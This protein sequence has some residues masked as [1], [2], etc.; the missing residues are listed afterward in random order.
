MNE[1]QRPSQITWRRFR[2]NR[3][4]LTGAI[5]L[6]ILYVLA[7]FAGFFS[8]YSPTNDEFRSH[9]YHP[10]TKIRFRDEGGNFHLRPFVYR[11]YLADIRRLIYTESKPL[12]IAHKNPAANT[13][14]YLPDSWESEDP[15]LILENES[16]K[17]LARVH[18]ME[19]TSENSGW[20]VA[21]VPLRRMPATSHLVIKSTLGDSVTFPVQNQRASFSTKPV[22]PTFDLMDEAG[23]HLLAYDTSLERIP[24]L[25]FV[26]GSDYRIFGVIPCNRHLFGVRSPGHIFLFGSDQWGRDIFSRV[27]YGAQISLSIGL[28]GVLVTTLF[29]LFLG[30]IAGYYGGASDNFIMRFAEILLS[31]P[32]LYLI[33]T[34]RNIIPDTL[35]ASYDKMN[36]FVSET[37]AWQQNPAAF[38]IVAIVSLLLLSY[39]IYRRQRRKPA[40]VVAGL[41]LLMIFF[42]GRI[43]GSFLRLV[44]LL[45]PGSIHLS[46]QWTYLLIVLILSTIGWA[47]MARVIRGMVLSL[48]EQEYVLAAKAAGASDLRVLI[49]HILPNTFGYVIV[50]ATLLI[51]AYILG[52]VALSFLSV[53][54]QEPVASWGNMLSAAQNLRVLQQFS[55]TLAPG[56][57][58]FV[59][60][61][62]FNF[63][64][65]G[66]R[67]AL[68]PRQR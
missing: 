17:I 18:E 24:M 32:A 36:L 56:Y 5:L 57:F 16:G 11:T 35:Q 43:A 48:R 33:L 68:D 39:Y 30:G 61:L 20:F 2:S 60:V 8:P 64:G 13:N 27:L 22:S 51:P 67:D 23:H 9:F 52:E 14:P 3:F 65:D 38:A 21:V 62:G 63:L 15:I 42:G 12:R 25:F 59:T 37:F 29:G 54:V 44:Q 53:G 19:E 55:W 28:V 58:L 4:A 66:L 45:L 10:P 34:L 40:F 47:A 26:K 1:T 31:I 46:S 7:A 41:W 50:R 6:A 49:R